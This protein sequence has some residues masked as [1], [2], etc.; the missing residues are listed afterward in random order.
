MWLLAEAGVGMTIGA[1][2]DAASCCIQLISW[3]RI[4]ASGF[5]SV[6]FATL[7]TSAI[8]THPKHGDHEC[9]LGTELA[10]PALRIRLLRFL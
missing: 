3:L 4:R 2:M 1:A 10:D 9:Q 7:K 8:Q 6:M 5:A